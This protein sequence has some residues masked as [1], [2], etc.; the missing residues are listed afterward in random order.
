[1]YVVTYEGPIAQPRRNRLHGMM[2]IPTEPDITLQH[3]MNFSK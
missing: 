3:A 1:V 2:S